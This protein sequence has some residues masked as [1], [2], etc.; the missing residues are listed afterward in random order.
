MTDLDDDHDATK[1]GA[2][3]AFKLIHGHALA[4]RGKT[5]SIY[6]KTDPILRTCEAMLT[7]L[8]AP[9]QKLAEAH[10]AGDF[11][12]EDIGQ[13]EGCEGGKCKLP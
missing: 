12:S 13:G 6:D 7:Q 11:A 1:V 2:V 4:M 8:G 3:K 9:L 10:H 5:A